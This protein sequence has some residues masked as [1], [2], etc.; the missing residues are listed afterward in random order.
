MAAWMGD[1]AGEG[2][3]SSDI[4]DEVRYL[5]AHSRA[6]HLE[7][8]YPGHVQIVERP[9]RGA[10]AREGEISRVPSRMARKRRALVKAG[11]C[12]A[13]ETGCFLSYNT[14]ESL[15]ITWNS[16]R[17]FGT[18]DAEAIYGLRWQQRW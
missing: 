1:A 12:P 16:T 2:S 11:E 17:L 14:D 15:Q 10:I 5:E 7:C 13:A 18:I 6:S 3:W 8:A 4:V 9:L